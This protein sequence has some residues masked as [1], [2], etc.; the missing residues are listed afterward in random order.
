MPS[1][2]ADIACVCIK[3]Q[4][5][6]HMAYEGLPKQ[7]RGHMDEISGCS[8]TWPLDHYIDIVNDLLPCPSSLGMNGSAETRSSPE[9]AIPDC[10]KFHIARMEPEQ[11][12]FLDSQSALSVTTGE[13]RDQLLQ[14]YVRW[15]HPQLP[16]IDA[17]EV[18]RAILVERE[19]DFPNPLLYQAIMFAG[20]AFVD[21]QYIEAAGYRSRLELRK[22]LFLKAK[23]SVLS[24]LAADFLAPNGPV[25]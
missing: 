18:S 1:G 10:S 22:S 7:H 14:A 12:E 13:L 8:S 4:D 5:V 11:I 25:N 24:Y 2:I 17:P 21:F 6:R 19:I 23:V 9:L 15:V 20:S 16:V 3:A